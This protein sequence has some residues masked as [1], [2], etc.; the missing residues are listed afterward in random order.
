MEN[1]DEYMTKYELPRLVG[2]RAAQL[3]NGSK[4]LIK[5][6]GETNPQKIALQE[7][8]ERKIP[9]QIKRVYPDGTVKFVD[10]RTLIIKQ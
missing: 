5:I 9:F 3:S 1:T 8:L 7:I 6:K 2:L 4:P 10:C